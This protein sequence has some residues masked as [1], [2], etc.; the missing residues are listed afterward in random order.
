MVATDEIGEILNGVFQVAGSSTDSCEVELHD[1]ETLLYEQGVSAAAEPPGVWN[2]L[3]I[4]YSLAA[5]PKRGA[6]G[7]ITNNVNNVP[8]TVPSPAEI[9]QNLWK[10]GATSDSGYDSGT[11]V[12]VR[13]STGVLVAIFSAWF[14]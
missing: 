2:G 7:G 10:T 3:A 6:S 5:L 13:P 4:S 1:T 9:F 12:N 14:S 11:A 8:V